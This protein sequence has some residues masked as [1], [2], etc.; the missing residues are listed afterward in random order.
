MSRSLLHLSLGLLLLV[1]GCKAQVVQHDRNASSPRLLTWEIGPGKQQLL[2][3]ALYRAGRVGDTDVRQLKQFFYRPVVT[4]RR[5]EGLYYVTRFTH[6]GPIGVLYSK[7]SVSTVE[8]GLTEAAT[9]DSVASALRKHG[10]RFNQ[11]LR[12]AILDEYQQ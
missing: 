2:A 12:Q 9:Q 11:R 10:G 7:Q 4:N 5:G 8:I 6:R 1:G 3:N